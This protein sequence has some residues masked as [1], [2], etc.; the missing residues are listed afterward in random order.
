M[1]KTRA[2]YKAVPGDGGFTVL[3]EEAMA[4]LDA[5]GF[6]FAPYDNDRDGYIDTLYVK[7]TGPNNGWSGFWWAYKSGYKASGVGDGAAYGGVRVN[8]FIWSYVASDQ[9]CEEVV[10]GVCDKDNYPLY[11]TPTDIHETGER[12]GGRPLEGGGGSPWLLAWRAPAALA[13]ARAPLLP[14]GRRGALSL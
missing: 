1:Q 2:Q 11:V 9:Y 3:I 6:D 5:S 7:W 4:A 14:S 12:A 8:T 13:G 10:K